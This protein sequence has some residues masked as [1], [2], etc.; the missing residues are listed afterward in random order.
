MED[1]RDRCR[2]INQYNGRRCRFN[3]TQ[4]NGYCRMHSIRNELNRLRREAQQRDKHFSEMTEEELR[5]KKQ[6][7]INTLIEINRENRRRTQ[8]IKREEVQV[9]L[10]DE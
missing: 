7:A 9:I 6:E 1:D 4:V 3:S 8:A 5:Q 2:G 10:V